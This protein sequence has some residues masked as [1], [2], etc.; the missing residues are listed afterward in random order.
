MQVLHQPVAM[1]N[2]QYHN[3]NIQS[4]LLFD[5]LIPTFSRGEKEIL[6]GSLNIY[7]ITERGT[8][9]RNFQHWNFCLVSK[10]VPGIFRSDHCGFR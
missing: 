6:R 9:T 5:T 7:I 3:V 8:I 2:L 4:P 10:A 1:V